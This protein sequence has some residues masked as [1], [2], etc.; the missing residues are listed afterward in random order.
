MAA[1]IIAPVIARVRSAGNG[2]KKETPPGA[3]IAF[4]RWNGK[5]TGMRLCTDGMIS[6]ASV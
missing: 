6:F 2:L 5:N 1:T 3:S 4:S